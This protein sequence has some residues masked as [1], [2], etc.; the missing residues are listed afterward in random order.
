MGLAEHPF[1]AVKYL[2][3]NYEVALPVMATPFVGRKQELA[4]I[5][6]LLAD[7]S[8][9]LL[10]LVGPG[11]IGKT[12]LALEAARR[13]TAD[14]NSTYFV[15]LQALNSPE[16]VAPAIAE[17]VD[18]QFDPGCDPRQ[19]LLDYLCE[20]SLLLV[21]DNFEHLLDGGELLSEILSAAPG[22][23]LLVTSRER[24]NLVEEWALDVGGLAYPT[25][26]EED[27]IEG[28]SAVQLF[29]QNAR[30]VHVG[31][32]LLPAQKPAVTRICRL[33][34]GMPLGIELA[35][36]W[37]RAMSCDQIANEI[38]RSLDIL[39][40][41]ARNVSPR[42]RNIRAALEH[43]WNLL[44]EVE[45]N[46]FM[47]LS[48]FRGGCTR[49]AA[50]HVT[51]ASVWT[52][53]AL[54]DKSLLR[55]DAN[56]RY[57]LHELLRQYAEE[58]LDLSGVANTTRDSHCDYYSHWFHERE[59][60]LKGHRQIEA[61]A[62][63]E[64]DFDNVRAM[65][66]WAIQQRDAEAIDRSVECLRLFCD[67]RSRFYEAEG[68]FRQAQAVFP[69]DSPI[70]GRIVARLLW[71]LFMGE[72]PESSWEDT[73]ALLAQ[74]LSIARQHDDRYETAFCI[75]L[76]GIA[77][78]SHTR[79]NAAAQAL[80]LESLD[81]YRILED[82]YFIGDVLTWYGVLQDSDDKTIA[83]VEESL[84]ILREAGALNLTAWGLINIAMCQMWQGRLAD[85]E[86]SFK[87]SLT[88]QRV[89]GDRKGIVWNLY[90]LGVAAFSAGDFNR[91]KAFAEET[92]HYADDYNILFGKKGGRSLLCVIAAVSDED[93]T[94]A[95][96]LG[97]EV[98]SLP[99]MRSDAD[100]R[101]NAHFGLALAAW[102]GRD[103]AAMKRQRQTLLKM[104]IEFHMPVCILY[105]LLLTAILSTHHSEFTRAVEL[106]A[107]TFT[108][109]HA[110]GWL[111]NWP[112]LN[113]LRQQLEANLGI[114]SYRT[115]WERGAKLDLFATGR[116]LLEESGGA[117]ENLPPADSTNSLTERELEILR[118]V[119]DGLSNRQIAE[120][121]I[122]SVGTVKWYVNQIYSKLHVGSR[123]QA[124]ARARE[125]GIL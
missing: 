59:S 48:V 23:R 73:D 28:Y 78:A 69:D 12:R 119:A 44:A 1:Y 14:T 105:T 42:H 30:R 95:R 65:W 3:R 83:Y 35:S 101:A 98:L 43:S 15:P 40:T 79:Q 53:T 67:M 49:P 54:V 11:G 13:L 77:A 113:R 97:E 24:L 120:Q 84:R 62:E 109:I 117:P 66:A 112:L 106:L 103:E 57:H 107:L 124:I 37:V 33:V 114:E 22:V 91:S 26:P 47:R 89:R 87:E 41:P 80:F 93:Y 6:R 94:L 123:T 17:A 88:I 34:G 100:S 51:S 121:L 9:R 74:C 81:H 4:E 39:Q 29:M 55:V 32:T 76:Q 18:C 21:L 118:L 63:I 85:A 19:Q 96:Q 25:S 20:K 104:G 60:D 71:M 31:F 86:A 92:L 102:S 58:Q 90:W 70:W 56:G 38:E 125:V 122:F 16:L 10:T 64:A 45:Q 2:G 36:V 61:L 8:C 116:A 68:L 7:D 110:T 5:M 75:Y 50:E 72:R 82:P 111:E 46:V 27:D 108:R 52:L 115:A 99:L